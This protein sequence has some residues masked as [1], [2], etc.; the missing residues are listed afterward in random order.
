M[1]RQEFETLMRDDVQGLLE[2]VQKLEEATCPLEFWDA[3]DGFTVY[4]EAIAGR[5]NTLG[6]ND[7]EGMPGPDTI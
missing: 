4:A 2:S 7:I 5:L 6:P 1:K 3:I